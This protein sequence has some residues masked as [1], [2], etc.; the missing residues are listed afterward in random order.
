MATL[1]R[2]FAFGAALVA[3]DGPSAHVD[4]GDLLGAL[5]DASPRDA[6]AGKPARPTASAKASA[7]ATAPVAVRAPGGAGRCLEAGPAADLE[8]KRTVG[9]PGCRDATIFEWKDR[10]GSPRYACLYG[11]RGAEP[12]APL[13]LLL[14]FHPHDDDP[15]TLEDRTG[16]KKLLGKADV[17]RDPAHRGMLVLAVQGRAFRGRAGT[18]FDTGRVGDDNADLAAVDH[19][20]GE[21]LKLGLVD[22]QRVYT[23]GAG[24]GGEMAAFVSLARPELVAAVGTFASLGPAARWVCPEAPAPLYA[25]YR[26]CDSVSACDRVEKHL[27]T[28]EQWGGEVERTRLD[29]GD[30]TEPACRGKQKCGREK[31]QALHVRWPKGR[32]DELVRFFSRHALAARK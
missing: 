24:T 5:E 29:E 30:G 27:E 20:V 13:P 1:A 11:A 14:Y 26:A 2:S 19:F 17:T 8:L 21:V 6:G 18:T 4:G 31:G 9:R 12:R 15:T 3:C 7:S 16:L 10:E 22:A 23:L 25:A 28:W 32:N